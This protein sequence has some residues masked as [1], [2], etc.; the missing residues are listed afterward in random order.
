MF[1]AM[2]AS[3]RPFARRSGYVVIA[4]VIACAVF[5]PRPRGLALKLPAPT[6]AGVQ[7]FR[8]F[9]GPVLPGG[10]AHIR[11]GTFRHDGRQLRL[12]AV[13]YWNVPVTCDTG[14][15]AIQGIPLIPVIV[16]P[17]QRCFSGGY[18]ERLVTP[19]W[20]RAF[21]RTARPAIGVLLPRRC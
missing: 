11:T 4:A 2:I 12:Y 13:S 3:A 14:D 21:G 5:G 20:R 15:S 19:G 6:A 7:D 17:H 18:Y 10:H 8:V 1:V 16:R 9:N